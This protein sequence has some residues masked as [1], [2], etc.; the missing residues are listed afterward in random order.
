MASPQP[1]NRTHFLLIAVT[2][3]AALGVAALRLVLSEG[4]IT[5]SQTAH[6]AWF[7]TTVGV[8]AL[9]LVVFVLRS[10]MLKQKERQGE[11]TEDARKSVLATSLAVEAGAIVIGAIGPAPFVSLLGG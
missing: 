5:L 4:Q 8:A 10:S 7:L 6:L 3:G 11:A 9:G 2:E 1:F